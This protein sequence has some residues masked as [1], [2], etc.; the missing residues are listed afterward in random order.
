MQ[1]GIATQYGFLYQRYAFIKTVL[2][3]VGMDKFFTYEG[4]DD[5]DMSEAESIMTIKASNDTFIQVKSGI[6]T[7]ECWAKVL[8][9]WL[10]IEGNNVCHTLM[11]ENELSFDIK[12]VDTIDR[13]CEYFKNGKAKSP[14]SIA[15]RVYRQYLEGKTASTNCLRAIIIE[16]IEHVSCVVLSLE[17][18]KAQ[19]ESSFKSIYCQDIVVYDMAKTCRFE[20]FIDY[21][22]AMINSS[23]EKKK[24][25]TIR[26]QTFMSIINTVTSEIS[27]QKYIIDTTEMRKRKKNEAE[28]LLND[29]GLREIRQLRQ[30]SRNEGFIVN[31][32]VKELLY[33]DFRN[34]YMETGTTLVSNMEDIAHINYQDAL[35]SL[36]EKPEAKQVFEETVRR[37]IPS[38]LLENSPIYRNG[39]YIFLTGQDVDNEQ[40]ITW[41]YEDE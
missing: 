11:L 14:T 23:L 39:C 20:R 36:P 31:E 28:K 4:T 9:N 2:D 18:I 29:N 30:V 6:V 13:V 3:N 38:S 10:L 41:G 21:T 19:I 34:V 26:Y 17:T 1:A 33:K 40:Q 27:D 7:R 16:L 22:Q 5:I 25:F 35:Y 32:L 8:G 24:S 12:S 37:P 15:N